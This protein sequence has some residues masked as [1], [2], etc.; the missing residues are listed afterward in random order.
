[1]KGKSKK[2]LAAMIEDRGEY[3]FPTPEAEAY[4]LE[5]I[6][7]SDN[8]DCRVSFRWQREQLALVKKAADEIGIPYQTY[9]KQVVFRQ[10]KQDLGLI[11][12][13]PVAQGDVE[14]IRRIYAAV[15]QMHKEMHLGKGPGLGSIKSNVLGAAMGKE[16]ADFLEFFQDTL[17]AYASHRGF[18]LPAR[19]GQFM[20]AAAAAPSQHDAAW[21]SQTELSHEA[22]WMQQSEGIAAVPPP[23]QKEKE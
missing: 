18:S 20:D 12:N 9:M 15:S 19:A 6:K 22:V 5:K 2:E 4:A 3:K 11:G 7:E 10:A 8:E 14:E 17:D 16:L 21:Y 23:P 1:M 13:A